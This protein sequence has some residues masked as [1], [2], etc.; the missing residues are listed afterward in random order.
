ML[1]RGKNHE[2]K[3]IAVLQDLKV[4]TSEITSRTAFGFRNL[5]KI[6]IPGIR[7]YFKTQDDIEAEKLDQSIRNSI[8]KMIQKRQEA[9]TGGMDGY[10]VIFM[11]N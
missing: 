8:I 3:E 5:Y 7:K 1:E 9:M 4:L 6:R 11:G 2:D 10:E